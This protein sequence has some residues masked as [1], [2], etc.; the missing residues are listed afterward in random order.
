[1]YVGWYLSWKLLKP[2]SYIEWYIGY[3]FR[4]NMQCSSNTI[5]GTSLFNFCHIIGNSAPRLSL[6]CAAQFQ[7]EEGDILE[8]TIHG[9]QPLYRNLTFLLVEGRL[10]IRLSPWPHLGPSCYTGT[11]FIAEHGVILYWHLFHCRAWLRTILAPVS[12][13]STS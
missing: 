7:V 13:P 3:S 10:P 4:Q 5:H 9:D 2:H 6:Q 12:L 8:Y 1:M 11:Y